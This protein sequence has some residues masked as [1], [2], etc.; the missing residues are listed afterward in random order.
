MQNNGQSESS[1][2]IRN[3][4][5]GA[6][7]NAFERPRKGQVLTVAP[8]RSIAPTTARNSRFCALSR[9]RTT[10]VRDRDT[11]YAGVDSRAKPSRQRGSILRAIATRI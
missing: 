5:D 4:G 6:L 10:P 7:P 3:E 2:N 1:V 11:R 8:R 9:R